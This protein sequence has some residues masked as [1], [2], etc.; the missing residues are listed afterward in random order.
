MQPFRCKGDEKR[1]NV[2]VG[3]MVQ[4]RSFGSKK[5]K[6]F[7]SYQLKTVKLMGLR[8]VLTGIEKNDKAY[9]KI[10][11]HGAIE[12]R[13]GFQ[14]VPQRYVQRKIAKC[15]PLFP[16]QVAAIIE[17]YLCMTLYKVPKRKHLLHEMNSL[18]QYLYIFS[19]E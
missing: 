7:H 2:R 15:I 5:P 8:A 12:G 13:C 9:L 6:D 18:C 4:I 3:D 16:A 11:E 19:Q 1:G 10:T 14:D 17:N